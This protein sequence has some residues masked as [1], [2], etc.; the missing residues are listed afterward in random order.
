MSDRF[1]AF[2]KWA[3]ISGVAVTAIWVRFPKI[4]QTLITL[5]ALDVASGIL[6]SFVMRRMSSS[7]MLRGLIAKLAVFPFLAFLHIVE[8]PL[9]LPF[10]LELIG[11]LGFIVY[12]SMSIV[13]NSA[14]AGV[15]IPIIVVRALAK[16]KVRTATPAQIKSEFEA[17][18][19]NMSVTESTEVLKTPPSEPDLRI[20]KKT[21][22][23]EERHIEPIKPKE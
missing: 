12:E 3:I 10:D 4:F 14:N 16:A 6:A 23:F 17:T 2:S 9:S 5:M 20:D 11:A 15:P 19:T 18:E 7:V 13:E 22:V 21:T 8:Q 1:Y